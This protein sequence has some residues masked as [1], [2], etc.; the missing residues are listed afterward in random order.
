MR[1]SLAFSCSASFSRCNSGTEVPPYSVFHLK[2][3]GP[4]DSVLAEQFRHQYHGLLQNAHDLGLRKLRLS[5]TPCSGPRESST[6][7]LSGQGKLAEVWRRIYDEHRP[8][9]S[10]GHCTRGEFAVWH[11]ELRFAAA[12]LLSAW[13]FH[14]P[15]QRQAGGDLCLCWISGQAK[16]TGPPRGGPR[17][18][19]LTDATHAL[20]HGISVPPRGLRPQSELC[21]PQVRQPKL[22]LDTVTPGGAEKSD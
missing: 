2:L 7:A 13:H 10:L 15:G 1:L 19:R 20:P 11:Q 17:E 6:Y 12:V 21:P 5:H 3:G 22:A 16:R 8:H 9:G 18:G 14:E 4:T